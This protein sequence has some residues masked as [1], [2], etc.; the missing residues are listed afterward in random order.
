MA[1]ATPLVQYQ[2][3]QVQTASPARL[4][5]MLYDGAIRFMNHGKMALEQRDIEEANRS[6]GKAQAILTELM[7]SLRLETGPMAQ[8]LYRIYDFLRLHLASALAKAD[9]RVVQQSIDLLAPIREAWL[10]ACV[11]GES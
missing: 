1:V 8:N 10:Q 5:L 6:I 3:T 11:G 4:I 7:A 9:P 2:L